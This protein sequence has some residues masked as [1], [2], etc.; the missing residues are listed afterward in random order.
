MIDDPEFI[1]S[2]DS[3]SNQEREGAKK[4]RVFFFFQPF[5]IHQSTLSVNE[6]SLLLMMMVI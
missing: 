1:D 4:S 3:I 2:M 6:I 5:K